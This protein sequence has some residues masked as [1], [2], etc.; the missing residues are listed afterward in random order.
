MQKI[1]D[2][3]VLKDMQDVGAP[4]GCQDTLS[5]SQRAPTIPK[6]RAQEFLS[7]YIY[8]YCGYG[9]EMFP[10]GIPG[11][12]VGFATLL[13]PATII[14]IMHYSEIAAP[15]TAKQAGNG[16]VRLIKTTAN[17]KRQR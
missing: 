8:I 2:R 3:T 12:R 17:N 11:T 13:N 16:L 5:A 9:L 14:T 15:A 10:I 7:I 6:P 4:N 1:F